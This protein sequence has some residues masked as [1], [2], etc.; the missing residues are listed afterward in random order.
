MEMN[1]RGFLKLLFGAA[2][3]V[4]LNANAATRTVGRFLS[5]TE[6]EA[7]AKH[8]DYDDQLLLDSFIE[9]LKLNEGLRLHFYRCTSE[10][11]TVGYGSNVQ[12]N[13]NLLN[14]VEIYHQG[15]ALDPVARKN[16]LKNL[17]TLPNTE[18]AT[19]T[20]KEKDAANMAKKF[21]KA[22]IPEVCEFL[23]PDRSNQTFFY[24]LPLCM[25]ALALDIFYNLGETKFQEYKKFRTALRHKDYDKATDESLVYTDT[26]KKKV[27]KERERRK[28]QMR[29]IM[30]F[31]WKRSDRPTSEILAE[32]EAD[33]LKRLQSQMD[34][35]S[36]QRELKCEKLLAI[37]EIE[38]M[39][40]QRQRSQA[41]LSRKVPET[42]PAP[43]RQQIAV[44]QHL[45]D[46]GVI[47]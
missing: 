11:V 19:Y 7:E 22:S 43:S 8:R 21:L 20:I 26:K 24:N 36:C 25:R 38:Q 42:K 35:A 3:G 29:D 17:K 28:H 34:P 10:K 5:D 13:T 33:C 32:L 47:R 14:G 41:I 46:R 4:A 23:C 27:N 15:Q 1:R 39:K 16:L 12:A 31:V 37:G 2:A 18:L 30:C 44:N 45:K 40:R 9:T 6:E